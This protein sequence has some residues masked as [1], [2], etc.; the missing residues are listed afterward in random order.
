MK[1]IAGSK[2]IEY[3]TK[4]AIPICGVFISIVSVIIAQHQSVIAEK[5]VMMAEFVQPVI[6][7]ISYQDAQTE[8]QIID[9]NGKAS[10]IKAMEP[11]IT[12]ES[13]AIK[14]LTAFGFDGEEFYLNET[15]IVPSQ[16]DISITVAAQVGKNP[17]I[18]D[19]VFYDYHRFCR[20][21][22]PSDVRK[23]RGDRG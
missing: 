22:R 3:I 10:A 2:A 1:K 5:E 9:N 13:G 15:S 7:T 12:I 23:R 6:Y 17:L 18:I 11:T 8:Y 21:E 20:W 4:I 16:D 19:Q 14:S